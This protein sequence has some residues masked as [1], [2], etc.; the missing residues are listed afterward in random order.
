MRPFFEAL[1]E[2]IVIEKKGGPLSIKRLFSI[3]SIEKSAFL[4]HQKLQQNAIRPAI[5]IVNG[6]IAATRF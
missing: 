6:V 2:K 5:T 3:L 4:L 1:Y